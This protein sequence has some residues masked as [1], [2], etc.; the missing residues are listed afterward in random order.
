M[1]DDQTPPPDD[2]TPPA[3]DP[4][5]SDPPVELGDAGKKALDAIRAEKKAAEKQAKELQ[6]ELDKLRQASMSE[7]E[8]AIADAVAAAKAETLTQVGSK[9]AVAEFKAAAAGRLDDGQLTALLGG[10]D[11]KA[12]LDDEGDV[13][14]AKVK[15]FVDTVAPKAAAPDDPKPGDLLAGLDLGQGARGN[16]KGTPGLGST[17]LERDLKAKLGIS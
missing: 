16:G 8:K 9:V 11:L 4:P 12:F 7:Q 2:A 17:Q 6:A 14:A 5:P 10:L 13:D 15:A 3:A 1:P